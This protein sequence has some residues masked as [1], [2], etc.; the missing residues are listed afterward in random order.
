MI[1]NKKVL[2]EFEN[3]LL[4]KAKPD[5]FKNLK[6]VESLYDEAVFFERLPLK[7]PLE[8]I[9]VDIK[10]AGVINYVSKTN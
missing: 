6:I 9:G 2:E 7:N 1:K 10:I 4:K 8:G 3:G 5:Y